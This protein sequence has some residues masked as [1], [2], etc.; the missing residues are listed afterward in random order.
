MPSTTDTCLPKFG[1]LAIGPHPTER[2]VFRLES[3]LIV[4]AD[5]E[6]VFA[7]F[8]DAG[9]LERLTPSLIRFR[10]LTPQPIEMRPGT[11]I[12]YRLRVRGVPTRWRTL[13]SVWE[14]PFR[15]VD[16]QLRGPY[17][18][19][20]HEHRFAAVEGGTLVSD[21]VDYRVPGGRLVNRLFVQPD[22]ARIFQYRR[23]Q[24]REIFRDTTED[25]GG[26]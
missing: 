8:A 5:L 9:N 25:G 18:S 19:W 7:F 15:F 16:E 6:R 24:L 21:T 12:D 13:I 10:I 26:R 1:E 4:P 14:P 23:E 22:V 2:G 3:R 11:L 20:R 17:R